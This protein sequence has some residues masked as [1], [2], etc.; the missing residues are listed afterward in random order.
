MR[1]SLRTLPLAA[2]AVLALGAAP[3]LA[4]GVKVGA[5]APE[6]T[7]VDSQ[8]K[9]VRLA[10]FRGKLVVLEWT[11]HDC[12]YVRKHYRSGNMQ[13]HQAEAAKDG[14]V[15]LTIISSDTG[16][17]GF[18]SAAEA[19]ALT[20]SRKAQPRHVLFDTAGTIGRAYD[21]KVTPHMYI[22]GKD[23]TLLYQGG[24]DSIASTRDADIERAKPYV[25]AALEE[26]KAGKPVTDHTTRA[27]G[28]TIKYRP[29]A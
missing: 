10:D 13:R 26:I 7:A 20:E 12:P 14:V 22:I 11:N 1:R 24:I 27:Y 23:G 18:V 4:A 25:R 15:W 9:T 8:G 28:C 21:A 6:F 17:Q 3:S 5:K 29:G 19:N 2:L 16:T